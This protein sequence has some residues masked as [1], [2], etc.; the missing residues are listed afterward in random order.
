[1]FERVLSAALVPIMGAA[2][3]V[4]PGTGVYVSRSVPEISG[5]KRTIQLVE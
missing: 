2:V 4:G 5:G 3:A 1:M